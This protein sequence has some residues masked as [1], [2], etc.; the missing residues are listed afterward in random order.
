M[1]GFRGL[2]L[3]PP[4]DIRQK[5]SATAE[6]HCQPRGPFHQ[7][8]LAGGQVDDKF[9]CTIERSIHEQSINI[10][11]AERGYSSLVPSATSSS[12][13]SSSSS[14]LSCSPSPSSSPSSPSSS[15]SS[16]PISSPSPSSILAT[17]PSTPPGR[18]TASKLLSE[19][20]SSSSWALALAP[21]ARA[22]TCSR[23]RLNAAPYN[24]S[25]GM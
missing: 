9:S 13:G 16:S 23:G 22:C 19:Q 25:S 8:L 1:G 3:R 20:A 6:K 11:I 24:T 18:E 4:T 5:W 17:S 14:P 12:S 15:S 7:Q 10:A 2:A 21:L